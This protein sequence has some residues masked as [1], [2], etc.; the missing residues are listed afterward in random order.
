M[1][2]RQ[3]NQLFTQVIE[4]H[5]GLI[6]KIAHSYVRNPDDRKDLIQEIVIQLWRSFDNYDSAYRYSTW[7]YKIAFNVSISFYR[8]ER[9][10]REVASPMTEH[11]FNFE[12]EGTGGDKEAHVNLL[13]Q[14]ISELE[15]LNKALMLL[16]LDERSHREMAEILGISETNVATKIGRIKEKLRKRFSIVND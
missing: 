5:K 6:Y 10:R 12:N 7:I 11:F 16:Y 3:K 8:Q 2:D 4:S 14:F 13:Y 9:R 1:G 15:E